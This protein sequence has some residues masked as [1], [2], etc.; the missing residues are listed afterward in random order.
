MEVINATFSILE[1]IKKKGMWR[2]KLSIVEKV[3][4]VNQLSSVMQERLRPCRTSHKVLIN[5]YQLAHLSVILGI[6]MLEVSLEVVNRGHN[7]R[8]Q[9]RVPCGHNQ[10]PDRQKLTRGDRG[11]EGKERE[12]L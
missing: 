1:N 8:Q 11:R 3:M 6:V 9:S 2:T 12:G 5:S 4:L 10:Q 7:L